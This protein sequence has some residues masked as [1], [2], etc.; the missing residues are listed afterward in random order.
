[1]AYITEAQVDAI[2]GGSGVRRGIFD[3]GSGY[4]STQFDSCADDATALVDAALAAAGYS[5]GLGAPLPR[6]VVVAT[7]GAFVLAAQERKGI[8]FS[9]PQAAQRAVDMF[10]MLRT[11]KLQI[12]G[13][14]PSDTGAVGGFTITPSDPTISGTSP[15]VFTRSS[16]GSGY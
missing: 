16:W 11:G 1:M 2:I 5:T 8:G 4:S 7:L 14:E 3:D 9:I 6:Q 15:Q 13:L 10:E 12:P